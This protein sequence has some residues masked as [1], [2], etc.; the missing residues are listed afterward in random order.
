MG[1]W[2][3]AALA[4]QFGFAVIGTMVAGIVLGQFLDRRLGTAPAFFLIGLLLGLATS[5]YLIYAIYR[6]QVQPGRS[7]S[8][9]SP[10]GAG[11]GRRSEPPGGERVDSDGAEGREAAGPGDRDDPDGLPASD[12]RGG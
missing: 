8:P 10:A 9:A 3:A 12:G 6:V 7:A 2:R 1:A 5:V 4:A 11:P